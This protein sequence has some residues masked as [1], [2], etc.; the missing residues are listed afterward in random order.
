MAEATEI[1]RAARD[2]LL[3]LLGLRSR[4]A[5]L[6]DRRQ[7]AAGDFRDDALRGQA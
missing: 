2:Q 1:C 4:E 3:G 6:A 5:D 7:P